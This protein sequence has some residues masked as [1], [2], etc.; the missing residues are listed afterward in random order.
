MYPA[1]R[2]AGDFEGFGR[3][4]R[5]A[6]HLRTARAALRIELD[7]ARLDG[8]AAVPESR[9]Q[10]PPSFGKDAAGFAPRSRALNRPLPFPAEPP[11]RLGSPPALR[12]AA[13]T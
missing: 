6:P 13:C 3:L 5:G 8:D 1:L 10:P 4:A 2:R 7:D 11:I 12:T 9:R